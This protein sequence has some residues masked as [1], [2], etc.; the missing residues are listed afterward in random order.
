[1]QLSIPSFRYGL[2][3]RFGL[4]T[5]VCAGLFIAPLD[6]A[7]AEPIEFL[8]PVKVVQTDSE[9]SASLTFRGYGSKPVEIFD[10]SGA[11][12]ETISQKSLRLNQS[13]AHVIA[14]RTAA[15]QARRAQANQYR[16]DQKEAQRAAA[17]KAAYD[18]QVAAEAQ[19]IVD[20]E[21]AVKFIE[22][23]LKAPLLNYYTGLYDP[24]L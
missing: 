8:T 10:R 13:P 11:R 17:E 14:R 6:L 21:D 9:Q 1:M 12:I 19:R 23:A 22:Q 15:F 3:A 24:I 7:V 5:L 2:S 4:A 20:L 16:I 18:A